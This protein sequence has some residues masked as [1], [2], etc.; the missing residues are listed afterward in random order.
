MCLYL[1]VI[2]AVAKENDTAVDETVAI[3]KSTTELTAVLAG[4][5]AGVHVQSDDELV[6]NYNDF[7][8]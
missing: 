6:R 8:K 2:P 5:I 1:A 4:T 3:A 7:K